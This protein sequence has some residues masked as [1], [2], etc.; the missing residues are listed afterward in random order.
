MDALGGE[1]VAADQL[2]QR[3]QRGRAGADPIGQR[4]DVEVDALAGIA[5]ALPVERLVLAVLGEQDHRQQA[6]PGAAA[7]DDMERRRR[8][9]DRLAGPAGELLAHGLDHLPVPRH[10]LQRLGDVSPSLASLPPQHGQARRR[11]GS[12]RARAAD[13]PGSGARAGFLRVNGRTVVPSTGAAA[14][15]SSAALASSFLELQLQLVEQL[16]AALGGL[17]ELLAP[18]LGDQQLAVRDQR[19]G[20][21]GARL[22]LLAR[23][24]LGGQRRRQRLDRC[25]MP[26][27][28]G[29]SHA[30]RRASLAAR[31]RG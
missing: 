18:Q 16:A 11:R 14:A 28:A 5:L 27:R 19:L 24:A 1:H 29:L 6:R 4:R 25:R 10:H 21:G 15:S 2:V 20:A 12:R 31:R 7:R 17:A 3:A 30:C 13:A 9:G 23:L 26:S 8:L 22:G